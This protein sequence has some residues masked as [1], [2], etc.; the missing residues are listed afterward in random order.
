MVALKVW[1]DK[2]I[3]VFCDNLAV[4]QVLQTAK[5][6]DSRLATFVRNI[7]LITSIFNMH[8]AVTHILGK[9]NSV[10]D[11]LS[12]WTVTPDNQNK[13]VS[14]K[15]R[16]QWV[17]THLDLTFCKSSNLTSFLLFAFLLY[18]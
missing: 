4:V 2:Y 18:F 5:A 17:P 8:L 10:A 13:L 12:R 1:K 15:P 3:E 16:F 6:R 14:M 7:L 11:L 9:N